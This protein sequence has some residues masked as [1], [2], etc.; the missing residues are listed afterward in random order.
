M[1]KQLT[2]QLHCIVPALRHPVAHLLGSVS[3][4]RGSDEPA[5]GIDCSANRDPPGREQG[6]QRMH[7]HSNCLWK[8]RVRRRRCERGNEV[9]QLGQRVEVGGRRQCLLQRGQARCL[10]R[11]L[12]RRRGSSGR[13]GCAGLGDHVVLR[14]AGDVRP[15]MERWVEGKGGSG[16]LRSSARVLTQPPLSR[17][18]SDE[19]RNIFVRAACG[20]WFGGARPRRPSKGKPR[21]K[22]ALG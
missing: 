11:H 10:R 5:L 21:E 22:R 14:V 19:T 13:R 4:L 2:K 3:L 8:H 15:G 20:C 6:L 9:Q 17:S 18:L 7:Q 16:G 12:G 1:S